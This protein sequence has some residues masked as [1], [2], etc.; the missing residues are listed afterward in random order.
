[1]CILQK[2]SQTPMQ[3]KYGLQVTVGCIVANNNGRIPEKEL[4]EL[5]DIIQAQYF[6]FCSEWKKHFTESVIQFYC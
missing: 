2:V 6:L 4:H 3:Q 1:M 5:M